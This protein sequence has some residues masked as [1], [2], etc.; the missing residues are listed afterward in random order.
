MKPFAVYISLTLMFL[1]VLLAGYFNAPLFVAHPILLT[2]V[3]LLSIAS[4]AFTTG[5]IVASQT[6]KKQRLRMERTEAHYRHL[7]ENAP[8]IFFSLDKDGVFTLSDG[9]GLEQLGLV[10]GEVVGRSIYEWAG[11]EYADELRELLHRC[12]T[13]KV[14]VAFSFRDSNRG[15][16][17]DCTFTPLHGQTEVDGVI[18]I[19]VNVTERTVAEAALRQ[20]N[21]GLEAAVALKTKEARVAT[22]ELMRTEKRASLDRLTATVAHEINTPVGVAY[23]ATSF[24]KMRLNELQLSYASECLDEEDFK[25]TLTVVNGGLDVIIQNLETAGDLIKMYRRASIAAEAIPLDK[26]SYPDSHVMLWHELEPL[27][28]GRDIKLDVSRVRPVI[29]SVNRIQANQVFS[30]IMRNAIEHGFKDQAT[31][32]IRFEQYCTPDGFLHF[33]SL[34]DGVHIPDEAINLVMEPFYTTNDDGKH[35]GLGLSIIRNILQENTD[36]KHFRIYNTDEG[37]CVEFLCGPKR[38]GWTL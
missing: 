34:N 8:I 23:T 37:V 31:G 10:P 22:E 24:V 35:S 32:T 7:L 1:G 17:F 38:G 3:V 26:V 21:E 5:L 25:E 13:E 33:R 2:L 15:V 19:G 6:F 18:G 11:P 29:L 36:L 30:N 9:K 12:V 20:A 28:G 4:A 27:L 14:Q 16:E